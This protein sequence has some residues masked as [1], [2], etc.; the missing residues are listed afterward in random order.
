MASL[1][2]IRKKLLE[3]EN[4]RSG[5]STKKTSFDNV[6]FPFWNMGNGDESTVRFLPDGDNSNTYFWV[7]KQMIN[8]PFSGVVGG[9]SETAN[10]EIIVSVPCV[11]MWGEQCPIHQEVR[12]WYK[13]SDEQLKELANVY[14]KKRTYMFQGFV[15]KTKMAEDSVPENPIRK[16]LFKPQVFNLIKTIILDQDVQYSPTHYEQGFDFYLAKGTKGNWADYSTSRWA[17]S[18]SALTQEERDAIDK[19]GLFNLSE[20]LPKKPTPQ[21]LAA[22]YEM[23]TVSLDGGKYDPERWGQF[24]RPRGLDFAQKQETQAKSSKVDANDDDIPFTPEVKPVSVSVTPAPAQEVETSAGKTQSA[25][26]I[27]A[28]LRNRNK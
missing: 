26:D 20:T 12:P 6:V 15:R 1:E 27:L 21:E 13:Q 23:F 18:A 9:D 2:E 14:W 4:R 22:I 24:Y 16:F 8:I 19:Y 5:N 10:K 11:E 7:E 17:R 3:Q 25:Q 28:A